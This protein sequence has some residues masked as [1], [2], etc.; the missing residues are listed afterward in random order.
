[1]DRV[2]PRSA[3]RRGE[4]APA[5]APLADASPTGDES[6]RSPSSPQSPASPD[7]QTAASP[8]SPDDPARSWRQSWRQTYSRVSAQLKLRPGELRD[9]EAARDLEAAFNVRPVSGGSRAPSAHSSAAASSRGSS[10]G[11]EPPDD[12]PAS[13]EE[14]LSTAVCGMADPVK[15]IFAGR[16]KPRSGKRRIVSHD[17]FYGYIG[18]APTQARVDSWDAFDNLGLTAKQRVARECDRMAQHFQAAAMCRKVVEAEAL[19]DVKLAM[20]RIELHAAAH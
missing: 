3:S 2:E 17:T 5:A 8:R 19:G 7:S 13:A 14:F 16:A 4:Q 1:M 9:D 15:A 6:P 10:D 20:P 18:R 11:A 12:A